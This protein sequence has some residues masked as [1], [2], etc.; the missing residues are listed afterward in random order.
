MTSFSILQHRTP[1]KGS[2]SLAASSA[3][4]VVATYDDYRRAVAAVEHLREQGHHDVHVALTKFAEVRVRPDSNILE[5]AQRASLPAAMA[6][7]ATIAAGTA[8]GLLTFDAPLVAL[9]ALVAISSA[10]TS[11]AVGLFRGVRHGLPSAS[12]RL[13]PTAY[14]VHCASSDIDSVAAAEA[15][16]ASWWRTGLDG[17]PMTPDHARIL[18]R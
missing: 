1:A 12:T 13:V 5:V 17:D 11:V 8:G 16:L 10:V 18:N 15:H 6:S 3:P 4:P 9:L 7:T 2:A 14:E